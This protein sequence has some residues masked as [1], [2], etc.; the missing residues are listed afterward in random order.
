MYIQ[1]QLAYHNH[2]RDYGHPSEF[3]YKD[4]LKDWNPK[5]LDPAALVQL[6]HDTGARFLLI[7][8]VHHDN[9][10]SWDSA[11]QPWNSVNVGPKRD[12]LKE[13]STAAAKARMHYGIA[14]QH[15]YAWW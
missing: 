10:D 11:Y 6:Y 9:F 4:I 5:K 2:L 3:G 8:D 1:G 13:W 12:L 14:F 15:E 7:Q